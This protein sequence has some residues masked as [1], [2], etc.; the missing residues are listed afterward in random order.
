MSESFLKFFGFIN[1][2]FITFLTL[3]IMFKQSLLSNFDIS[4]ENLVSCIA[5]VSLNGTLVVIWFSKQ[6]KKMIRNCLRE[7]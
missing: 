5:L 1:L 3:V 7:E 2:I 4:F 6:N